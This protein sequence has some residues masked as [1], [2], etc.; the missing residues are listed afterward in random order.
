LSEDNFI[1]AAHRLIRKLAPIRERALTGASLVDFKIVRPDAVRAINQLWLLKFWNRHRT[2]NGIPQ[3]RALETED[4]KRIKDGAS[5]LNVIGE[6]R[7]FLIRAYGSGVAKLYDEDSRGK[8]LDEIIP[9][10]RHATGLLPY[11]QACKTGRP[12]Y[13]ICDV[14]DGKGRLIH[15]ERLILPF[16]GDGQ[17]VE[18]ILSAFEFVCEDGAFDISAVNKLRNG[19]LTLRLCAM[20]DTPQVVA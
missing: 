1:L 12:V 8:F 9:R 10:A 5:F 17:S 2:T 7:R 15:F 14:K 3:W 19:A 13:T 18:H 20:I 16:L 11:H 4:L 6:P